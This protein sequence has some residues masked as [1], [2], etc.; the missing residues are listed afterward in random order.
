VKWIPDPDASKFVRGIVRLAQSRIQ[1]ARSA[2]EAIKH[3]QLAKSKVE[4]ACRGDEE[5]VNPQCQQLAVK[6][7][8]ADSCPVKKPPSWWD[9][10]DDSVLER[11]SLVH[12]FEMIECICEIGWLARWFVTPRQMICDVSR[13]HDY[14]I[15]FI[16]LVREAVEQLHIAEVAH[17][18]VRWPNVCFFFDEKESLRAALIDL[19]RLTDIEDGFISL[20][21]SELH[22]PPK[23]RP[24]K[25]NHAKQDIRQLAFLGLRAHGKEGSE[26]QCVS[27]RELREV[28]MSGVFGADSVFSREQPEFIEQLP[29]LSEAIRSYKGNQ[30]VV[31]KR[32]E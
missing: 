8:A 15:A 21:E 19:D 31:M 28:K 22:Q 29:K 16:T 11:R 7:V 24:P 6:L 13:V 14:P 4:T 20:Y 3:E 25:W 26:C 5:N 2:A 18:D 1:L 17:Q 32:R 10:W 9:S 30:S 27:C 12:T 23:P